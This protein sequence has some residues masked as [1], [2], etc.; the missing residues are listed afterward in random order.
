MSFAL[1]C[2]GLLGFLVI[3]LGLGVSLKR[4]TTKRAI[5]HDADPADPLHKWVRAHANAC[6]YVP[7]LAI[8]IFAL[9]NNGESGWNGWL[10]L[11]AVVVRYAH[12]AGMILSPTL[13]KG[14]PLRFVGALGTY[15]VGLVLCAM[16]V[17]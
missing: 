17:C 11:A 13:A 12:A 16:V 3:G 10:F 2:I 9:A 7:I 6:E 1:T 8:L 4:D 5:G 14:H 15:V